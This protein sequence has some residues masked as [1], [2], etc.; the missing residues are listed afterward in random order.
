MIL[1][2]GENNG[3]IGGKVG[4]HVKV[5][6]DDELA[7]QDVVIGVVA[8]VD[9]IRELDYQTRSVAL[10]VGTGVWV[11]RRDAVVGQK[12]VVVEFVYDDASACAFDIGCQ[13]KP[14]ANEVQFLVLKRVGINGNVGRQ[15]RPDWVLWERMASMEKG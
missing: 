7:V 10:L 4:N 9:H 8:M 3:A 12:F 14:S 6:A 15:D 13:V 2:Q 11:V 5:V 1:H